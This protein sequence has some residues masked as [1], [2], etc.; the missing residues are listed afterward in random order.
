[1]SDPP[2]KLDPPSKKPEARPAGAPPNRGDVFNNPLHD[3]SGDRPADAGDEKIAW[4]NALR[5]K[6]N[7]ARRKSMQL[8][9]LEDKKKDGDGKE[10][11]KKDGS[12]TK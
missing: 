1:M 8:P 9:G 11:D 2:K 5:E 12:K 10:D 7:K 3:C 4:W 6:G